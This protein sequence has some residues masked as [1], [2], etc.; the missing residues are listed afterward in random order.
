[1]RI[2][3]SQLIQTLTTHFRS[4]SLKSSSDLDLSEPSCGER[5]HVLLPPLGPGFWS[6][7]LSSRLFSMIT[8]GFW[9][10][11]LSFR[12]FSMIATGFWSVAL[13][14]QLFSTIATLPLWHMLCLSVSCLNFLL[15]LDGDMLSFF[16]NTLYSSPI[17]SEVA[18]LHGSQWV[19]NV[20]RNIKLINKCL[21]TLHI[22]LLS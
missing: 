20:F 14:S 21:I 18:L 19:N 12:L 10:V 13:S 6:V 4:G 5:R 8:T 17:R 16:T 1:M 22:T 3:C 7:A 15:H 2:C 9:S 11:P